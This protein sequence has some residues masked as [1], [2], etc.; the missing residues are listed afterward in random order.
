M[1]TM[2]RR[3][4]YQITKFYH[5]FLVIF[6]WSDKDKLQ[7]SINQMQEM[8]LTFAYAD[9]ESICDLKKITKVN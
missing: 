9:N 2:F 3:M 1:D 5:R 4:F 6:W 7:K 8:V